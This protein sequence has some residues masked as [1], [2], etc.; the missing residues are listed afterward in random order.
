MRRNW[1][2]GTWCN[3]F[4]VTQLV[5]QTEHC[6]IL[7][8]SVAWMLNHDQSTLVNAL[9]DC[10]ADMISFWCKYRSFFELTDLSSCLWLTTLCTKTKPLAGMSLS[11]SLSH[12]CFHDLLH[13]QHTLLHASF[14]R[15]TECMINSQVWH[16]SNWFTSWHR[17]TS[18]NQ[19]HARLSACVHELQQHRLLIWPAMPPLLTQPVPTAMLTDHLQSSPQMSPYLNEFCTK[20]WTGKLHYRRHVEYDGVAED[21]RPLPCHSLQTWLGCTQTTATLII[22][23]LLHHKY[24]NILLLFIG[25]PL[26]EHSCVDNPML[27]SSSAIAQ[28]P[29]DA[30]VTSIHKTAKWNFWATLLAGLGEM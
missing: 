1:V 29:R 2:G 17:N 7:C 10:L 4:K 3:F 9:L 6:F 20:R 28:K 18:N 5:F 14:C 13:L 26:L 19:S 27:T 8:N 23:P 22:I 25:M 12:V 21:H 11:E 24:S 16:R 15:G 30:R